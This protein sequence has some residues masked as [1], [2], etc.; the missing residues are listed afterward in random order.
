MICLDSDHFEILEEFA[1]D[2]LFPKL[3]FTPH[4]SSKLVQQHATLLMS[5]SFT[6]IDTISIQ[7][8]LL[9]SA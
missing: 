4:R 2:Q 9:L 5:I 1:R 7:L 8:I 3:M 6:E